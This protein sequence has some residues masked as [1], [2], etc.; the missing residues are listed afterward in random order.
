MKYVLDSSV[1]FKWLVAEAGT[2]EALR[3]R[4]AF[5]QGLVEL[6]APDVYAI[7]MAH[8]LT[9]AE[10]QGRITPQQGAIFLADV[11]ATLPRLVSSVA[12]VPRA[13]EISSQM[14]IGVYDCLYVA[15]AE[16]EQC[17]MVTVDDWLIRN[18]QPQFPFIVSLTALP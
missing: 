2:V 6:A 4:D 7:E 12:L 17:E 3:L 18:L 10:R 15:L 8:S 14:R 1:A 13:Y 5:R 11:L 9:R 16:Q